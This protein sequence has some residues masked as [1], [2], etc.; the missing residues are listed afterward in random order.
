MLFPIRN[1]AQRPA[2]RA[3]ILLCIYERFA[4]LT[5]GQ[6]VLVCESLRSN[7]P[8]DILA[9]F[10]EPRGEGMEIDL[11]IHAQVGQRN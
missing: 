11:P 7:G 4:N 5:T 9:K 2:N 8:S 6:L 10:G 3:S 1:H